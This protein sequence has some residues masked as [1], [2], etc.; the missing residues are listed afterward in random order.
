MRPLLPEARVRWNVRWGV[1]WDA[2]WNLSDA[3][4]ALA[5]V[6]GL[7]DVNVDDG[8]DLDDLLLL[9]CPRN[10]DD[11]VDVPVRK[12]EGVFDG[13]IDGTIDGM[14]GGGF[15]GGFDGRFDGRFDGMFD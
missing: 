7:V 2:R 6:E 4:D 5:V 8:L 9:H 12:F 3:R 1:R 13:T 11:R 15:D 14:F 10:V